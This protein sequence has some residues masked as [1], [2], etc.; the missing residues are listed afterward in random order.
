M[1]LRAA[2]GAV[3][4]TDR[5][6]RLRAAYGHKGQ[7]G[8]VGRVRAVLQTTDQMERHPAEDCDTTSPSFMA[9]RGEN[10]P[11]NGTLSNL[12]FVP[13]LVD[14]SS[15]RTSRKHRGVAMKLCFGRGDGFGR[16]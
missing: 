14:F 4:P 7:T 8:T 11:A 12:S 6:D 15:R 2:Y 10:T 5:A 16:P 13:M 3:G 1:G 9:S